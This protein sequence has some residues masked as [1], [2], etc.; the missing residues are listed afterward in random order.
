MTDRPVGPSTYFRPEH[1]AGLDARTRELIARRDHAMGGAYRLFYRQPVEFVRGAG[2]KLYSADGEEFLDAYNNVPSVG[3]AHPRV[4][5]AIA[6]QAA[7]LNTHTRYLHP[8]VIEYSER[9][10]ATMPAGIGHVMLTC[11][12]SEANDL[13]LRIARDA[14]GS[15]G[16][17]VTSYAYHGV[18]IATAN[19][20]PSLIG[21]DAV[22]PWVRVVPSPVVDPAAFVDGVRAAIASLDAAGLGLAALFVDTV[23]SSDGVQA[24]GTFLGPVAELVRAAGGLLV[25]D[26]VQAGFGRMG[27]GMWGFE[28]HGIVP[29]AV[30]FGK[31]AGNGMPIA[32]FAARDA[33]IDGFGAHQRYFNTFGGTPVSVAAAQAV[34][35]VIEGEG[36]IANA[37][38]VGDRLSA[39]VRGL[40]APEIGDVRGVGLYYGID[41]VDSS[42]GPDEPLALAVVN[43]MRDRRVLI[44]ASGP[45]NHT[46]KVRPPLP[47]DDADADRFVAALADTLEA[48]RN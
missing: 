43:G 20:S 24:S 7:L 46:L 27:H 32:G 30:T 47:F 1:S 10:L 6:A 9:L 22:E 19:L 36:L 12:G 26:E 37:A 13:A 16:A 2:T 14:T 44:A 21:A 8:A 33:V 31:P 29:D 40:D 42:G 28:R 4:V 3:H 15:T 34:L 5:A 11:T 48:T 23:F 18:T 38:A 25:A 17:I 45:H 35:D 39:A 41:I